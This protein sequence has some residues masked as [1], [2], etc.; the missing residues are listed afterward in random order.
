M[1]GSGCANSPH[2]EGTSLGIIEWDTDFNVRAW[3]PG[4]VH[5][6][7]YSEAEMAGHHAN[8]IVPEFEH[9]KVAAIMAR[10]ASG[11]KDV[12]HELLRCADVPRKAHPHT[13]GGVRPGFRRALARASIPD[14]RTEAG[15]S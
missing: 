3:S 4:A 15:D 14:G 5:I 8:S 13:P 1:P 11:E 10:L 12:S 2:W 6:F 7:G 9:E